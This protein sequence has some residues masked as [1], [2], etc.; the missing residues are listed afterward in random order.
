ME[1]KKKIARQL[2]R[3][4]KGVSNHW[5]VEI[6]LLIAKEE[7]ISLE[8]ISK[9]LACN[10]KTASEHVRKLVLAGL[11]DKRYEGRTVRHSLTPYG[12]KMVNFMRSF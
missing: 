7:G 1:D 12:K 8:S 2:E 11:V 9:T 4:F 6:L 5:R 3:V 10:M